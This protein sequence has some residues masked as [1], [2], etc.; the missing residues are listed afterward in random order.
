MALSLHALLTG[1]VDCLV[2]QEEK[3]TP[4]SHASFFYSEVQ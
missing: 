3:A 2:V 4:K 1:N